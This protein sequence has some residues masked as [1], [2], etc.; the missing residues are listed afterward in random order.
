MK[1]LYITALFLL[2]PSRSSS[3]PREEGLSFVGRVTGFVSTLT[4]V[5]LA[6]V[7]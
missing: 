3:P 1:I 4:V 2:L 5:V 6:V 7:V